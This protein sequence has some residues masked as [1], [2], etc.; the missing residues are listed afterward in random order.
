MAKRFAAVV[1][2]ERSSGV[3]V[4]IVAGLPGAHTQATTLD[5]LRANLKEV[6]QLCIEEYPDAP[7]DTEFIGTLD[8][9]V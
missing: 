1:T 2:R 9:E 6:I 8:I 3:F 7:R 5:D 4:G